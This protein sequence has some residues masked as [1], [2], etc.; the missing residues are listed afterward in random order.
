MEVRDVKTKQHNVNQELR[1]CWPRFFG[2]I[3]QLYGDRDVVYVC[4]CLMVAEKARF[5]LLYEW[6]AQRSASN[7]RLSATAW[8][9][10]KNSN[11]RGYFCRY[12]NKMLR[13]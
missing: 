13:S 3:P 6:L 4:I 9:N 1:N 2:G 7:S 12:K 11:L 5:V 8:S 10:Q